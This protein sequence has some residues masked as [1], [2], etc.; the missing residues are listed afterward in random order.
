[1][2]QKSLGDNS[3]Q[4]YLVLFG[5]MIAAVVYNPAFTYY[6]SLNLLIYIFLHL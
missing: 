2:S 3:N 6:T 4:V 5:N 1:M